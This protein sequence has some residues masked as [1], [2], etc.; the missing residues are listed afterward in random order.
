MTVYKQ[1]AYTMP[2]PQTEPV[3]PHYVMADCQHE[4]YEGEVVVT[5]EN[6]TICPDCFMDK[7]ST[8]T[9]QEVAHLMGVEYSEVT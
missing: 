9:V 8:M 1:G 7:V 2:E 3:E 4:V 6:K 5:W